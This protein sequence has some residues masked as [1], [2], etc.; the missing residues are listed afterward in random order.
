MKKREN[1]GSLFFS[2][3]FLSVCMMLLTLVACANENINI[4]SLPDVIQNETFEITVPS[5]GS[6]PYRWHY[7]IDTKSGIEFVSEKYIPENEDPDWCGGVGQSKYTFKA[8]KIGS[9]TIKFIYQIIGESEP[10]D[11]IN[12]YKI[13]VII[14]K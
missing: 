4:Y 1:V 13:N 12:E 11:I 14:S 6:T 3:L 7:E 5:N 8:T 2:A 10:P 9:Y